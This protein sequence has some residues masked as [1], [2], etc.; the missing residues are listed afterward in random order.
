MERKDKAT[1][2]ETGN[3][4][5]AAFRC[6]GQMTLWIYAA[7]CTHSSGNFENNL[8]LRCKLPLRKPTLI[9]RG[10]GNYIS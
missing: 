7:T 10:V 6:R 4:T 1:G 2:K 8:Y 5:M 9:L 3:C